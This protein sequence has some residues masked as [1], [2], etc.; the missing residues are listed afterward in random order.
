MESLQRPRNVKTGHILA[1]LVAGALTGVIA[2]LVW[3]KTAP[4]EKFV[5]Y[6]TDPAGQ[7]W[8]RSLIMIVVPLVFALVSLGVAGLGELKKLGRLGLKTLLGFLVLA[9]LAAAL[10]LLMANALRPGEGLAPKTRERLLATYSQ[11]TEQSRG[12]GQAPFGIQ[13]LVNIVPRNP[14]AA[15]AQGDMLAVIFFSVVF[16]VALGLLPAARSATLIEALRG[17][18]GVMEVIID[19]VMKLAPYGAFA[20]IFSVAARFGFDLLVKLGWYVVTVVAGLV[21]FQFGV[22]ALV[23][24]FAARRNPVSFFRGARDP[25]VTAFSTA[26]SNATLPTTVRASETALNLPPGICGF[27]LPLG[28]SMN[29]NG[30]ALF[31]AATV[32]FI[33]QVFGIHL[34]LPKQL[35]VL[36][37][38]VL[39]AGVSNVGLPGAVIPLT[40]LVLASVGVPSE[41]IALIVGVDRLL[42]M[43]RTAVN[44]TGH[45]VIAECVARS[46]GRHAVVKNSIAHPVSGVR[47]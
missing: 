4:L 35:V 45:M 3:G 15:A 10:G 34:S 17:L 13:T 21:L 22:Y 43:C 46:E 27:V 12:A 19:L 31:E 2:N 20:L 38:T 8:L 14:V 23:E 40:I 18:A 42:D 25:M 9:A 26:S 24:R 30:S 16:G 32:L 41:G 29:K 1:G 28:A 44:V 11:E 47:A 6:V 5:H 36:V 37:L 7:I 33:A 39:T